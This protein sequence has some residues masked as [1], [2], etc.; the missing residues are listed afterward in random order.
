MKINIYSA[1]T[2]LVFFASCKPGFKDTPDGLSYLF[3]QENE[4]GVKAKPG[5][6]LSLRMSYS[7]EKD[8]LL[9]NSKMISDSFRLILKKP[10]YKG[11]I[12][13]ALAMLKTGDSARFKLN[14]EKFYENTIK[15]TLPLYIPKESK[16]VFNV[17]LLKITPLKEYEKELSEAKKIVAEKQ[18]QEIKDY[19]NT[20]QLK[21]EF[22]STGTFFSEQ[23]KGK[24]AQAN[25]E[26]EVLV[27]YSGYFLD[28]RLVDS[29]KDK[30]PLQ[31][32]VGSSGLVDGWNEA[33][34]RMNEG[35]KVTIVLP[36]STA[37]GEEGYGPV[38]PFTPLVFNIEL[39]KV[40]KKK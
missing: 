17:R 26:D 38:P 3:V 31:C 32:K 6:I 12:N 2:I 33:L 16:I 40:L 8:C 35:G 7:T 39:V 29:N 30:K 36:S 11:D 25:Y 22:L 4:K 28:G 15:Q 5:D 19:V 34:Q 23:V 14:A 24:G 20:H 10:Q 21:G 18:S 1:I 37:Y 13:E 9:F 27:N